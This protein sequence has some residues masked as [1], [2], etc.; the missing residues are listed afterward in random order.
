VASCLGNI[1]P[2]FGTVGPAENYAHLPDLA[3]WVLAGC[4]LLGR[5]EIYTVIILIVPEFWK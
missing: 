5:L 2:G 1:G 4:M 3:K